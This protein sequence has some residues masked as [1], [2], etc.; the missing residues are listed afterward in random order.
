MAQKE[1]KL[2]LDFF[3]RNLLLI[4]LP[5][6]IF[7]LVGVLFQLSKPTIY[8]QNAK[9]EMVYEVEN[10]QNRI[11]ITDQAVSTIRS[12]N[13]QKSLELNSSTELVVFKSGPLLI[14]LTVNSKS[15][16]QTSQDFNKVSN[17]LVD[18]YQVKEVGLEVPSQNRDISPLL[19]F[20][21]L[22]S[23]LS[24]GVVLSLAREYLRNY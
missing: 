9:Y 18:N 7:T 10:I 23:G 22:F 12:L 15:V 1:S 3:R 11:S 14:D 16:D 20:I 21:A 5:V 17:Y 4:V 24:V 6:L 2:F 19:I 13:L 8:S